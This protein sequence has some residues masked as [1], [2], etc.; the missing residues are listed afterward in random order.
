[1]GITGLL[2]F[3]KDAT[4][5]IHIKNYAGQVVAVD[6]YCWLH[7]GSF[8]CAEKLA[9]K[10]RTDQYV[11]YCLKYI[12]LLEKFHVK[13]VLVF[14]GCR[15]PSK[16]LVERQRHKRRK[17][18]L[19]KGKQFL[20]EGKLGAARDCFTKCISVTPAM[21]LE[22]MEAA[23]ARGVDCIVAPYEA[24]AQ[25]AFLSKS[26][27]A[28][29][30]IT[31]DSD[32]LCFGCN[33]VIFKLDLTGRAQEISLSNLGRV[34]NLVGFTPDLF[35][36]MC[37]LSGCDYL[38]SVK[39]VGLVKACKALKLSKSKD[40]YQVARK[41]HQYIKGLSPVDA[42]Y[43]PEFER[44]DKTFLYQLVFD[45]SD[46][47]IKPLNKYPPGRDAQD[48]P[49]A[50]AELSNE[51]AFQIALGNVDVNTKL[52]IA[53]F[54]V[55]TWVKTRKPADHHKSIWST[56]QRKNKNDV[57]FVDN[58][59]FIEQP[60]RGDHPKAAKVNLKSASNSNQ[61]ENKA[62]T[63]EDVLEAV[64]NGSAD[65]QDTETSTKPSK[66]D[67][68]TVTSHS[69]S[70]IVQSYVPANVKWKTEKM[71]QIVK[72]RYFA[73]ADANLDKESSFFTESSPTVASSSL[74]KTKDGILDDILNELGDAVVKP[75]EEYLSPSLKR[76]NM[77][78]KETNSAT[79]RKNLANNS[80]EDLQRLKRRKKKG[81]TLNRHFTDVPTGLEINESHQSKLLFE[82]DFLNENI[83][84][85]DEDTRNDEIEDKRNE[86]ANGCSSSLELE[87]NDSSVQE[88]HIKAFDP[89]CDERIPIL[90]EENELFSQ[91]RKPLSIVED[92]NRCR[93]SEN[94]VE[95]K[96]LGKKRQIETPE[97]EN[98]VLLT[99]SDNEENES[100][101][102]TLPQKSSTGVN[103][104]AKFH[105]PDKLNLSK[106]FGGAKASGLRK[107]K[108]SL[109]SVKN[110]PS[111][112]SF[113][114][115]PKIF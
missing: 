102:I 99:I 26:G 16:E 21:A 29:A 62:L 31:E 39:G 9:K 73:A 61:Q 10:E 100:E 106:Y 47:E 114:T 108:K 24:D 54:D 38:P 7:R 32:L 107:P 67:H 109:K 105:K 49:Y 51:Q 53:Y 83:L 12:D 90:D 46:R 28:R 81:K 57:V 66:V 80:A 14:D 35:R 76:K 113:F 89:C 82:K 104:K 4:D 25:L 94:L 95:H 41:L 87:N 55:D 85:L 5:V 50:G 72:S 15:L 20:R 93:V 91:T 52:T 88:E 43:G 19:D 48:F 74:H 18:N 27:I 75:Q 58:S 59:A 103:M 37:I 40:S 8:A 92:S 23:R 42:S 30:I 6:T 77:F 11:R 1:M 97:K 112:A 86:D 64:I 2:P 22:V 13:P 71:T 96:I 110:Q 68:V 115:K 78:A 33:T 44:A 101:Y 69:I 45:P 63:A 17:E 70:D 65:M 3:V 111:I 98:R 56:K 79:K 60:R 34:K 36:Q 84:S